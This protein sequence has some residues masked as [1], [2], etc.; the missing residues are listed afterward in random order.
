MQLTCN[1][2]HIVHNQKDRTK[3]TLKHSLLFMVYFWQLSDDYSDPFDLKKQM[4]DK[5]PQL[6]EDQTTS[7]A[8]VEDLSAASSTGLPEDDYSEPYEL[9]KHLKG[10]Y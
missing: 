9:K 10:E 6:E 7:N 2:V 5:L 4:L 8:L 1:N 3:F